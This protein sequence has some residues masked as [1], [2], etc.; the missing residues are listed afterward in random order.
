MAMMAMVA[1]AMDHPVCLGLILVLARF[2]YL[3]EALN[4]EPNTAP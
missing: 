3:C 2:E 4:P 1:M